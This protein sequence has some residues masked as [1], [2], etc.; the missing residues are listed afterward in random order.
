MIIWQI[1]ILI[2][3]AYLVTGFAYA[4]NKMREA[5]YLPVPPSILSWPVAAYVNSEF[6]YWLMFTILVGGVCTPYLI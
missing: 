2:G 3:A 5:T 6:S 1:V 4:R